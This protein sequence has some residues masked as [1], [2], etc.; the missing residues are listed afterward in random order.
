MTLRGGTI[1]MFIQTSG[2]K[3][4]EG[5]TI[6]VVD[7]NEIMV[8]AGLE[9][10]NMQGTIIVNHLPKN[11]SL[12]LKLPKRI[13]VKVEVLFGVTQIFLKSL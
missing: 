2:L 3:S 1:N 8:T 13:D 4:K 10:F 11:L 12:N 7:C 6:Y 9:T 5:L